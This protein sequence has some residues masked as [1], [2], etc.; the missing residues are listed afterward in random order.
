MQIAPQDLLGDVA[1]A[2]NPRALARERSAARV[3]VALRA[4]ANEAEL[5]AYLGDDL[6]VR[7]PAAG[8]L[9]AGDDGGWLVAEFTP[10]TSRGRELM[11]PR[12]RALLAAAAARECTVAQPRIMGVLNVTPDSFSDGGRWN[13]PQH[14]LAHALE[15]VAQGASVIDV[16][17][18]S[19]RP[20]SSPID[21]DEECHRVLPVVRALAQA[22]PATISVDTTK[23]RVAEQAL[24]LG[25]TLVND[26]SGGRF[27]PRMIPLVARRGC[28]YA[29]MHMQGTPL[30][31]QHAPAYTDVVAQVL[32][33]LR[34][35]AAVCWREGIAPERLWIDPGIGFGKNLEH[36]LELIARLGELRSLGL[37][38]LVGPSRKSFIGQAHPRASSASDRI[39]G[40]AAA[41]AACVFG[42]AQLLRVHDV[43]RMAEAAS[44]AWAIG[45]R[46]LPS[47]T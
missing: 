36:N 27:D 11:S 28:E 39:G 5:R 23:A 10:L 33:F 34:E 47:A 29:L 12:A 13:D 46:A 38:I 9:G 4:P 16:G 6:R 2:L 22:T 44:V 45:R 42:G 15:L 17:G 18:E 43:E 32:A 3:R 1:Q 21:V 25:A 40:T 20:G 24:D 14:A 35:R 30:E 31:M 26:I 19:S 41:L 7:Q 8:E 37:R